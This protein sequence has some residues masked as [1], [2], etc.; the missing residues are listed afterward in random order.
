MDIKNNYFK[1]EN[2]ITLITL[3]VTVVVIMILTG[4]VLQLNNKNSDAVDLANQ[5]KEE[6]QI[7][8]IEEEIKNSL[9]EN[10]PK[11]YSEL[12]SALKNYGTIENENDQEN[13]VLVT[14]EGNYRILV[15]DIWNINP[16]EVPEQE[17]K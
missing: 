5:K 1:K 4:V 10:E 15:K 11:D 17:E 14:N 8:M 9:L 12:I 13:A 2:G 6:V 7:L 3:V 16:T